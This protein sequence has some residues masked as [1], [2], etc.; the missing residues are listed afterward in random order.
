[1]SWN[2]MDRA[3]INTLSAIANVSFDLQKRYIVWR[4]DQVLSKKYHEN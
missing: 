3:I 1:M 2:M 4:L